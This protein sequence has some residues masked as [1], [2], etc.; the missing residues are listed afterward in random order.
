MSTS[1][2]LPVVVLAAFAAGCATPALQSNG[3]TGLAGTY[4]ITPP[5]ACAMRSEGKKAFCMLGPGG[6]E[7]GA[8]LAVKSDRF[9]PQQ[10]AATPDWDAWILQNQAV[11]FTSEI[12]VVEVRGAE[13]AATAA[14]IGAVRCLSLH[15]H[16]RSVLPDADDASMTCV[17]TDLA[18][19]SIDTVGADYIEFRPDPAR[20]NAG[21]EERANPFIHSLRRTSG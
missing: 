11:N 8:M 9:T 10:V 3:V 1:K 16:L 6:P 7:G 21:F 14:R 20:P 13:E 4:A 18:S 12:E 5:S 2:A 17:F 15:M 19:G